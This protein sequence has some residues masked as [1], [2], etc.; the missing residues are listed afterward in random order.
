MDLKREQPPKQAVAR[1]GRKSFVGVVV[2]LLGLAALAALVWYLTHQQAAGG[3]GPGGSA[4][5]GGPPASTVGVATADRADIPV[6]VEA[7][8]TV[9]AAA[10]TTVRPQ[11]SGVLKEILF[12]EGQQVKAGQL[13]AVIDPRQFEMAL[14]QA[15][16]QRQRDEAQ[17]QN[18]RLTLERY[19]TLLAQD[20]IARQDVDTQAALVKQLEGTVATDRAAEGTAR[21]NLGY[22]KVT[23]P[24]SGRVGLRS[25]DLGNVV[26]PS[27][28][29]GIVV[30]TQTNPIDVEFAIPQDHI[31]ELSARIADNALLPVTALDRTRE[32]TLDTG[33][34]LAMDNQVDPQTGTIRAKARF[35]NTKNALFPSQFVNVRLLLR[36][37]Q[38]AVVVPVSALRHNGNGDFVYVFDTAERTVAVRQVKRGLM[39]ADKVQIVSGLN[40]GEQVITEGADRLRDGARV[41]LPGDRPAGAG[42]QHQGGGRRGGHRGAQQD[43]A[44]SGKGTPSSQ[45][46]MDAQQQGGLQ[47]GQQQGGQHRHRAGAAAQ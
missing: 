19:R 32:T 13:L 31:P 4:R 44:A 30:I 21:L 38:G 18:A 27:D 8:G 11:V 14:M 45:P 15:T 17:L 29:N 10:V 24:I 3:T 7:L 36:T 9:T 12:A 34:F 16:G 23:A 6:V 35:D 43:A 47:G 20:S 5:R 46:G 1:A 25:V 26:S 40:P 22:S 39:S 33:K 41:M 37:E 28:A 42:G 2:A